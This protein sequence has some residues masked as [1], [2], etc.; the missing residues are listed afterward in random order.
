MCIYYGDMPG[1][2]Y[3]NREH[4][5]PAGLGGK[6]ML[7]KGYV[8]DQANKLFSPLEMSLMRK[9]IISVPRF[10]EGPGKRGSLV[11][12]RASTS[13]ICKY[14]ADDGTIELGYIK[15][16]KPYSIPQVRINIERSEPE[17]LFITPKVEN[18]PVEI[19][20]SFKNDFS[21]YNDRF[22]SIRADELGTSQVI[23]AAWEGKFY[24][25]FGESAPETQFLNGL[26]ALFCKN[27]RVKEVSQ[28]D[29]QGKFRLH[30]IESADSC[31]VYAKIAYNVL[32]HFRGEE[33]VKSAR[34]QKIRSWILGDSD[35]EEFISL[36]RGFKGVEHMEFPE[37]AHFCFFMRSEEGQL[38]AV[39]C[40]YGAFFHTFKFADWD[41]SLDAYEFP[42]FLGMICDW[43]NEQ[44]YNMNEWIITLAKSFCF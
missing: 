22:V 29:T 38:I 16:G 36:P 23:I 39:V 3:K 28:R 1:L 8:S 37:K 18:D 34:F 44:E 2:T 20:E 33:F 30:L 24:F 5:F 10:F 40:L 7:Q 19:L 13:G 43:K 6:T 12:S 27:A 9:S 11:S 21:K 26:I 42:S 35:T 31:R 14:E 25:A 4:I 32:A 15:A 17:F 41:A